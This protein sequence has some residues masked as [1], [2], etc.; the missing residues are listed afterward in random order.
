MGDVNNPTMIPN[1]IMWSWMR[2]VLKLSGSELLI[3]S[4]L[5]SQTFDSVHK[6]YTCLSDMTE[7]FGITRQTISRNIDKLVEK[8]F[9]SKE[10]LADITNPIIKHN[11]YS[12]NTEY[13]TE[14]CENSDYNSYS[15]FLDSYRMILHQ[16]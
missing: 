1:I 16:K 10:C 2:T 8:N 13:I 12:V 7:W 11:N 15:N 4:Y 9:V 14:L 5:F 3:F 6:C